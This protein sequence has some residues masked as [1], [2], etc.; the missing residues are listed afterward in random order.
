MLIILKK[1]SIAQYYVI[2]Y[3]TWQ[4]SFKNDCSC[5]FVELEIMY[6]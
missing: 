4:V 1:L 5:V 3:T 2:Q 6:R